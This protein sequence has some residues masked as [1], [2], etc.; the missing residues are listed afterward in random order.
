MHSLTL[1]LTKYLEITGGEVLKNQRTG[2]PSSPRMKD[3]LMGVLE[4]ITGRFP[5]GCRDLHFIVTHS[6]GLKTAVEQWRCL[7]R[8]SSENSSLGLGMC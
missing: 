7:A 5:S 6:L 8:H 2:V 4:S 1:E 3:S